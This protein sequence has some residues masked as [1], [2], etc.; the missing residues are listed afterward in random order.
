MMWSEGWV[1]PRLFYIILND[2][3]K[4][5]LC[6]VSFDTEI[7]LYFCFMIFYYVHDRNLTKN[8]QI[9]PQR[10]ILYIVYIYQF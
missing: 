6:Y 5:M 1:R 10:G 9:V 7:L 4:H 8:P 3:I 2:M